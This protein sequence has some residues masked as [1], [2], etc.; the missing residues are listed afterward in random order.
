MSIYSEYESSMKFERKIF[1]TS[2]EFDIPRRDTP[3]IFEADI[4][5]Y[6]KAVVAYKMHYIIVCGKETMDTSGLSTVDVRLNKGSFGGLTTFSGYELAIKY[7]G[8]KIPNYL[9]NDN[10]YY[11]CFNGIIGPF[12]DAQCNQAKSSSDFPSVK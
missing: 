5:F 10:M 12:S 7:F 2:E 3:G 4:A 8:A 1:S 11:Q 9:N 6:T